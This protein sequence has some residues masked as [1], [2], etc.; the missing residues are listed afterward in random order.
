MIDINRTSREYEGKYPLDHPLGV[1]ALLADLPVLMSRYGFDEVDLLLDFAES[2]ER[3]KLTKK[4]RKALHL[5]F[6]EGL[7]QQEAANSLGVADKR[8][9]NNLIHRAIVK[10]AI[11]NGWNGE[12]TWREWCAAEYGTWRE[13]YT[14]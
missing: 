8:G 7:T 11:I 14:K 10:I 5:V 6:I 4:Q 12:G 1:R 2:I 9:V 3:A 13:N